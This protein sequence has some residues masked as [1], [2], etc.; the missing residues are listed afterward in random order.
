[1]DKEIGGT[2]DIGD[3]VTTKTRKGFFRIVEYEYM[4]PS[5]SIILQLEKILNE[6]GLPLKYQHEDIPTVGIHINFCKDGFEAAGQI[7]LDAIV[8]E[9]NLNEHFPR[10]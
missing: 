6:R 7:R 9:M 1:M 10:S 5:G 3:I 4:H 2:F 8:S